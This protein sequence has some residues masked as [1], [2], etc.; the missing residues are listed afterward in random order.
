LFC[1]PGDLVVGFVDALD[2]GLQVGQAELAVALDHDVEPVAHR[3]GA[4][5]LL[6]HA[7]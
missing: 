3:R 2:V 4:V 7:L 1:V 6:D 5:V